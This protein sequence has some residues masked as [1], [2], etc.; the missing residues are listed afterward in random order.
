MLWNT[1]YT[2]IK[3]IL[4]IIKSAKKLYLVSIDLFINF[5]KIDM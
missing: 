5:S 1:D 2:D 3:F 4:E